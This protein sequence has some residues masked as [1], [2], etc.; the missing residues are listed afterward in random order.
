MPSGGSPFV[1]VVKATDFGYLDDFPG[2]SAVDSTRLCPLENGQ[3]VPQGE[4]LKLHGEA[5]CATEAGAGRGRN[6]CK[7]PSGRR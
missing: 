4:Y 3:L 2:L 6:R 1:V 7:S 5:G